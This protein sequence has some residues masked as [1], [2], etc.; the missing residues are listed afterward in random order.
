MLISFI[1]CYS[2]K[3]F[4]VFYSS[5]YFVLGPFVIEPLYLN[6]LWMSNWDVPSEILT[7]SG[8][9]FI[10][11]GGRTCVLYWEFIIFEPESTTIELSLPNALEEFLSAF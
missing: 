1:F 6:L 2:E 8:K 7:D 9:E 3:F 11:L 4:V 10:G 5:F